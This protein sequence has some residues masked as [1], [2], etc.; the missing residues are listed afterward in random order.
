MRFISAID[1]KDGKCVRLYKGRMSDCKVYAAS[2]LA[3]A[4]DF[5]LYKSELIH[6]VDLDGAVCGS[7]QNFSS[8]QEVVKLL[9]CCVQV[10]G[11]IRSEEDVELYL[12]LGVNRVVL[13]TSVLSNPEF[14]AYISC[15]YP[16]RIAVSVDTV[17]GFVAADGWT[18][19]SST[20]CETAVA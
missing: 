6:V 1:I 15:R 2:P 8:I 14:V 20:G 9:D 7:P 13:G 5:K 10:G 4:R 16:G 11:G 12:K 18:A 3:A 19:V 17:E